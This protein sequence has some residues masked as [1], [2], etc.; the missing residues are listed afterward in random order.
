MTVSLKTEVVIK[1]FEFEIKASST[2]LQFLSVH[3]NS[4]QFQTVDVKVA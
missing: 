1:I 3:K 4:L 2:A